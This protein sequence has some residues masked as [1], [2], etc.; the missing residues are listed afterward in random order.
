[1]RRTHRGPGGH[2]LYRSYR[3]GN[4]ERLSRI[5]RLRV[6]PSDTDAFLDPTVAPFS[7]EISKISPLETFAKSVLAI[8]ISIG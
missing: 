7:V 2:D 6:A 4:L 5:Y 3:Q 8:V 1:M